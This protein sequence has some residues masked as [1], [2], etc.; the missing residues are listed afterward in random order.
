MLVNMEFLEIFHK[1]TIFSFYYK[2]KFRKYKENFKNLLNE[3]N[4]INIEFFVK[5]YKFRFIVIFMQKKFITFILN[6]N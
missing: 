3:K 2:L 5:N 1:Y 6:I 4:K